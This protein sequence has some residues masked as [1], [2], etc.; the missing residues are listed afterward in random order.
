MNKRMKLAARI[1]GLLASGGLVIVFIMSGVA[2]IMD[3]GWGT[4]SE[5]M[6]GII[7]AV[8]S[9]L[10]L[11]GCILSW[12]RE[13]LAGIILIVIAIALGS[14]GGAIAGRHNIIVGLM[15]CIPLLISG[16]LFI[17]SARIP[18]KPV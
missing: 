9:I 10:A 5:D 7:L 12:W 15:L 17:L 13:Q 6:Q 16:V 11:A 8:L 2:E 18:R 3:R 14:Y 1:I 4:I